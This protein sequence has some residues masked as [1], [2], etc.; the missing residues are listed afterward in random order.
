MS[1][2]TCVLRCSTSTR[3]KRETCY[4][5]SSTAAQAN[6]LHRAG[7]DVNAQAGRA[8]PNNRL[9]QQDVV[10]VDGTFGAVLSAYAVPIKHK[11]E[12]LLSFKFDKDLPLSGRRSMVLA[13]A[14]YPACQDT[15]HSEIL[16]LHVSMTTRRDQF[17]SLLP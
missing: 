12:R 9:R 2:G 1:S 10:F 5:C 7:E 13:R 15:Q 14:E 6:N 11:Y 17:I 4:R 3:A 16:I 8:A